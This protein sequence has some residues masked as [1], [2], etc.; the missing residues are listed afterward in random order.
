VKFAGARRVLKKRRAAGI[1]KLAVFAGFGLDL[2][3]FSEK[4]EGAIF[5]PYL[6]GCNILHPIRHLL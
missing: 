3:K 6:I 4:Q 2:R 1:E 5:C